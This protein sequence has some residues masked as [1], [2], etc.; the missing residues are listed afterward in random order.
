MVGAGAIGAA[1]GADAMVGAG[2]IGAAARGG[3]GGGTVVL[4]RG[5]SWIPV[6]GAL[7]ARRGGSGGSRRAH[8]PQATTSSGFSALQKGQK[9]MGQRAGSAG[10]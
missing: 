8:A 5:G 10:A 7:R 4:V 2:A 3:I 9:R 1:V 6:G